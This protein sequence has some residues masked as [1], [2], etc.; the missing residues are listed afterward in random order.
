MKLQI[1]TSNY[2]IER[3]LFDFFFII[4]GFLLIY[5]SRSSLK[6]HKDEEEKFNFRY[7]DSVDN[8]LKCKCCDPKSLSNCKFSHIEIDENH[9]CDLLKNHN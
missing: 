9:V 5:Y 6:L 3:N 2:V 1:L 7:T 4:L 8:C